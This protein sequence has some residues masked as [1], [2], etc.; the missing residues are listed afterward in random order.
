MCCMKQGQG[1][2]IWAEG[3]PEYLPPKPNFFTFDKQSSLQH[4]WSETK[5]REEQGEDRNC[6][7]CGFTGSLGAQPQ[8]VEIFKGI[9]DK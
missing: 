6:K 7:A 5:R 2:A 9:Q 4:R 1:P 8:G 3:E